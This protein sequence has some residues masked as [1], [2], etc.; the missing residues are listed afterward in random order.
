M[1]KL[2]LLFLTIF[3]AGTAFK[4]GKPAYLLYDVN[5]KKAKYSQMLKQ[6]QNADIILFGELH[7]NPISHW[8]QLVLTKDLHAVKGTDLILGAEMFES[9][10][11]IILDEYLNDLISQSR[12]EAEARIWTNYKSDY[13]PLVEF[14]KKNQIKFVATNIPRRYASIVNTKGFEGLDEISEEAKKFLPP[15][16]VL[17]N[18]ELNAYKNMMTMSG[19]EHHTNENFP[20]AQAIKDATMAHFI[21]ENWEKGKTLIHYHGAYHSDHFESIYWYLKQHN[22][23]L[24]IL[25][26]TTVSQE[27]ISHVDEGNK[28]KADFI[29]VVDK[30]MTPTH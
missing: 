25:T 17:Y 5:S 29:I 8:L 30:D 23:E 1:K 26:I 2:S 7:N 24:Q 13:K 27:N 9:D 15:L 3:F 16:P 19:M 22:P 18:P 20:K 6:A 14:A 12:F 21:I 11:Q 4:T 10:N 28:E